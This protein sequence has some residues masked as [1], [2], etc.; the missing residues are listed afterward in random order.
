LARETEGKAQRTKDEH[1]FLK[2]TLQV[3]SGDRPRRLALPPQSGGTGPPA[4]DQRASPEKRG[5]RREAP[6][7]ADTDRLAA[8]KGPT[9]TRDAGIRLR[10]RPAY[11]AHRRPLR[12][13]LDYSPA[14][15]RSAVLSVVMRIHFPARS[16][17]RP[18]AL[19]R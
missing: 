6:A 4:A 19:A 5:R 18:S 16:A 7:N 2:K 3:E 13:R 12:A 14:V 15:V 8:T 9:D 1:G 11:R 17:P 10:R